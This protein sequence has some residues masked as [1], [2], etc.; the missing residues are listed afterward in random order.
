MSS[1]GPR[2]RPLQ[3]L[4]ILMVFWALQMWASSLCCRAVAI[5]AI[6]A[7]PAA[8]E[9]SDEAEYPGSWPPP[10]G[11]NPPTSTTM[12]VFHQGSRS[13]LSPPEEFLKS[14]RRVPSCPDPLHNR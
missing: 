13:R 10:A 3:C 8:Q 9:H 12:Q 5:R 4:V 1:P 11:R 7:S 2:R 14:M 6:P